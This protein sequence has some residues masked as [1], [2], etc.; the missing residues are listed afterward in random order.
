VL[1]GHDVLPAYVSRI[2]A[3][4]ADLAAR[5]LAAAEAALPGT[6]AELVA[7]VDAPDAEADTIARH[8]L[9]LAK[10]GLVRIGAP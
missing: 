6:L 10:Q 3:I 5:V 4:S 1:A 9:W 2:G 8:A 7:K